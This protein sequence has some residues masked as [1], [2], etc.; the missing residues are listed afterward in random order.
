M[1]PQAVW[2]RWAYLCPI[3]LCIKNKQWM[4]QIWPLDCDL[5]SICLG[6]D[7]WRQEW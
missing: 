3:Q 4:D 1:Q 5:L 7:V 2:Y 6:R